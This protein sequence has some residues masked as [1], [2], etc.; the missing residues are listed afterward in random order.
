MLT[1]KTTTKFSGRYFFFFLMLI[2]GNF[3]TVFGQSTVTFSGSAK[4]LDGKAIEFADIL[5]LQHDSSVYKFSFIADGQFN[6]SKIDPGQYILQVSSLDIDPFYQP[7]NLVKDLNID[8]VLD[9]QGIALDE[10]TIAARRNIFD[11][12]DGNITF[13]IANTILKAEPN[14]ISILSKL[15][16]I[17][18]VPGGQ[19]ISIVGRGTP[20]IYRNNQRI[21][22]NSINSISVDDIESIEIINNPSAKY[23]A[24]GRSVILIRTISNL[25]EGYKVDLKET[26]SQRSFF[27]NFFGLNS[28]F[29][30]KKSEFRLNL[31]FNKLKPWEKVLTQYDVVNSSLSSENEGISIANRNEYILGAG[32]YHP[33]KD[34]DYFSVGYNANLKRTIGDINAHSLYRI[35]N[36]GDEIKTHTENKDDR[37]YHNG[38]INYNK[39]LEN[40]NLFVGAQFASFFQSVSTFIE[41]DFDGTGFQPEQQRNQD[42]GI[43]SYSARLDYETSLGAGAK[44]E[45]GLNTTVSM[46]HTN[47]LIAPISN[48]IAKILSEYD[49]KEQIHAAYTQISHTLGSVNLSGGLRLEQSLV[50][51]KFK[52]SNTA[53][54]D[55]DNL[56]FL[57]KAQISFPFDSLNVLTINYAS[58]IKRPN[59][60]NL[61][62]IEVY[63][64]PFLVFSRNINLHPTF[65]HE[66][67]ANFQRKNSSLRLSFSYQKDPVNWSSSYDSSTDLFKTTLINFDKMLGISATVNVPVT[68]R[69][70]TSFNTMSANLN[71][72]EDEN[73]LQLSSS[74]YIYF[75]TNHSFKLPSE[76]SLNVNAWGFS[77]RNEGAYKRNALVIAGVGISKVLFGKLSCTFNFD[78]IF[79][80]KSF[81]EISKVKSVEAFNVFFVDSREL[82]L[83][84]KY[85]FGHIKSNY[86]NKN[87]SDSGNR[88]K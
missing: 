78:N 29:K 65:I 79:N 59:F 34:K 35:D 28:S 45:M 13:N 23:E 20:L 27:N 71:K 67:A 52:G 21:D 4:D 83:S 10:V 55:R 18:T 74:P 17:E 53:T 5:L 38:V 42:F 51:G 3:A 85:S 8:L 61:S 41:N 11:N 62:Q 14:T 26:L 40:G 82:S 9:R 76:F 63:L 77:K 2:L 56:Y 87:V 22:W 66:V 31:G 75:Y 15:P 6:I 88:V 69:L 39:G 84:L 80:N 47:Q 58:N 16:Y 24:E 70:W 86:K 73:A 7:L 48:Q 1:S 30:V 12:K 43:E 68:Y 36:I 72:I 33:I 60:S 49:Y 37:D 50:D 19:S 57:P 64:N 54:V 25:Q 46:A 44:I 81:E 32:F